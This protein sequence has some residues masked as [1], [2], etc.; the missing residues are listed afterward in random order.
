MVLRRAP[1]LW[2]GFYKFRF[3][4]FFLSFFRRCMLKLFSFFLGKQTGG[5][6]C[7]AGEGK[8]FHGLVVE[9]RDVEGEHHD[10]ESCVREREIEIEMRAGLGC[11]LDDFTS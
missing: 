4:Y 5:V 3:F 8:F 10:G 6:L 9:E 2:F 11:A 1:W 7:R